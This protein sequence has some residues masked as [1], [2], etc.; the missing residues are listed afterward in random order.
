MEHHQ[1]PTL[2]RTRFGGCLALFGCLVA[3]LAW[4][5]IK[6]GLGAFPSALLVGGAASL[7]SVGCGIALAAGRRGKAGAVLALAVLSFT[8]VVEAVYGWMG[9]TA[10]RSGG[11]LDPVLTTILLVTTVALLIWLLYGRMTT[12]DF[13]PRPRQWTEADQPKPTSQVRA[14]PYDT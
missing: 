2:M 8:L 10:T 1:P 5:G 14:Q 3:V 9:D 11:V 13:T 4:F 12:G 6:S 7:L